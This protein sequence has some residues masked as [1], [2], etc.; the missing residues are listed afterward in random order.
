MIYCN[1][2]FYSDIYASEHDNIGDLFSKFR[3]YESQF[4]LLFIRI[5]LD[6]DDADREHE[7][8]ANE[9]T[10]SDGQ[11]YGMVFECLFFEMSVMFYFM[12]RSRSIGSIGR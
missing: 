5:C 1:Y 10:V 9:Y 2:T 7:T 8:H 4:I 11:S 6:T 3:K 12:L